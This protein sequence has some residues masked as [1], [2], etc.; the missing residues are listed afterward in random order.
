MSTDPPPRQPL[1]PS[2]SPTGEHGAPG[3]RRLVPA[4][5]FISGLIIGGVL[6]GVTGTRAAHTGPTP[7]ASSPTARPLAPTASPSTVTRTVIKTVTVTPKPL[8]ELN[9]GTYLVP[10][11]AHPGTWS[12]NG[13]S[14]VAATLIGCYWARLK[15]LSGEA[16]A[17]IASDNLAPSAP[18]TIAVAP[19]DAAVKFTGGCQWRRV[20]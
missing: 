2:P 1:T 18:T 4:A 14:D 19:T 15:S 7:I 5:A 8:S 13:K 16:G 12:T 6:V 3:L 11:Q 10:S 9:D 17:V 20:G